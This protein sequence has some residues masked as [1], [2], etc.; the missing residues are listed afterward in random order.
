MDPL[1]SGFVTSEGI[2]S[3]AALV[4]PILYNVLIV[5]LMRHFNAEPPAVD[6]TTEAIKQAIIWGSNAVIAA[7]Y[8]HGRSKIKAAA[9][10]PESTEPVVPGSN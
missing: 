10:T 8:S 1:R 3:I 6:Q 7:S 9:L 4:A 2:I 5:P